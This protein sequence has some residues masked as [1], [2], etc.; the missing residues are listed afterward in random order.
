MS[1]KAQ[2]N[3]AYTSDCNAVENGLAAHEHNAN[4]QKGQQG[5]NC[6][7][8]HTLAQFCNLCLRMSHATPNAKF[9]I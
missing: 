6:I 2:F 3:S 8:F 7:D 5:L 4:L 9:R 1:K